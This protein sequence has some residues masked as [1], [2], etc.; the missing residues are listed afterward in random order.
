[1]APTQPIVDTA[2]YATIL[3]AVQS[4][5]DAAKQKFTGSKALIDISISTSPKKEILYT[6]VWAPDPSRLDTVITGN[7]TAGQL[8]EWVQK[9]NSQGRRI[10]TI[11]AT[12]SGV[13]ARFA[14]IA[15]KGPGIVSTVNAVLLDLN[16]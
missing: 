5:F 12:G 15:V 16:E 6:A 11:S 3:N 7:D 4:D 9:C 14:G 2:G 10:T 1:M 13:D 8:Q